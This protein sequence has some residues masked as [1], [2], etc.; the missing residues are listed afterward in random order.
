MAEHMNAF[1]GLINQAISLEVPFA[2]EALILLL[3]SYL[4][5]SWETLVVTLAPKASEAPVP[6]WLQY[7]GAHECLPRADKPGNLVTNTFR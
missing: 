4:P 3:L 1:Q 6:R 7:G 2:D 5:D